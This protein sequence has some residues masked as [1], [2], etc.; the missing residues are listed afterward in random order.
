M[1]VAAV[2]RCWPHGNP[3][4]AGRTE[5]YAGI[6]VQP[7]LPT[8]LTQGEGLMLRER[9]SKVLLPSSRLLL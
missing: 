7:C 5:R 3:A 2:I 4:G 1:S 6:T 9:N 8:S